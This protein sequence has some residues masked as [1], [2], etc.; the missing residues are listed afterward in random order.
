MISFDKCLHEVYLQ[1][2]EEIG[3]L[4]ESISLTDVIVDWFIDATLI[5]IRIYT[6]NGCDSRQHHQ[7]HLSTFLES[8]RQTEDIEDNFLVGTLMDIKI[9]TSNGCDSSQRH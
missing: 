1:I 2:R 4:L 8:M 3:T 5:G 6:S 7:V 9:Y